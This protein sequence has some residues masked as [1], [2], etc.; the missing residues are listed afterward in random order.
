M[1]LPFP[2]R[3][4]TPAVVAEAMSVLPSPLKSAVMGETTPVLFKEYNREGGRPA[5]GC[6]RTVTVAIAELDPEFALSP[7]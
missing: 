2:R 6:D 7:Q 3:T 1:P 4:A 5:I